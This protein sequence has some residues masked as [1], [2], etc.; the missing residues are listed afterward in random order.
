MIKNS[1]LVNRTLLKIC[2][3]TMSLTL[4]PLIKGQ[5]TLRGDFSRNKIGVYASFNDLVNNQP[6]DTSMFMIKNRLGIVQLFTF[7]KPNKLMRF[8]ST[9][10]KYKKY[11]NEICFY[12]DGSKVYI[13]HAK[14]F[15]PIDLS[16]RFTDF[17]Y[18]GW[19]WMLLST[20]T[21]PIPLIIPLP[22]QYNAE[23]LYD[24]QTDQRYLN[25]VYGL[26]MLLE[27]VDGDLLMQFESEKKKKKKIQKYIDI[28]NKKYK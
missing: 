28:L 15:A 26:I 11:K 6:F 14:V 24:S 1:Q 13:K 5:D 3:I 18:K 10:N 9:L 12:L 25:N 19:R 22:L 17:N 16:L 8:D 7:S 2:F 23:L 4:T 21:N 27:D 20:Y